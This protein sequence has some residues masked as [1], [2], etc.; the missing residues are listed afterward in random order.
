[1]CTKNYEKKMLGTSSDFWFVATQG[2]IL[3]IVGFY[4]KECF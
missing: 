3:K 1:M 2:I 4:L